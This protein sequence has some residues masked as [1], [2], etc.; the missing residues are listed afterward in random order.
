M[1]M[2]IMLLCVRAYDRSWTIQ[3]KSRLSVCGYN[4][5]TYQS[6]QRFH[7]ATI[8]IPQFQVLKNVGKRILWDHARNFRTYPRI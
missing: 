1:S 3:H 7:P 8:R 2:T 6:R 4:V 5:L